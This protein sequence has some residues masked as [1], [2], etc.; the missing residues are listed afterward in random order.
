MF[1]ELPLPV[2]VLPLLIP[3]ML[4]IVFANAVRLLHALEKKFAELEHALVILHFA[5]RNIIL[6]PVH[7]STTIF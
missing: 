2:K 7:T 4:P 6:Q 5:L 1:V 3:A